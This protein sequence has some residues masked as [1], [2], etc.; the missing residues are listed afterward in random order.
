MWVTIFIFGNYNLVSCE[1]ISSVLL[2]S[3]TVKSIHNGDLN[4][5]LVQFKWSKFVGSPNGLVL[6]CQYIFPGTYKDTKSWVVGVWF[7]RPCVLLWVPLGGWC[8]AL[9]L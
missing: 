8:I 5:G 4:D 7:A 9:G 1:H 6:E 3:T 2:G